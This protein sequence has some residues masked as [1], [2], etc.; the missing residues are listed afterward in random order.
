MQ[1]RCVKGSLR[2]NLSWWQANISNEYIIDVI[3]HGYR[4]PLLQVPKEEFLKNNQSARKEPGFVTAE[5]QK[6]LD[7]GI[8]KHLSKPPRVVNAL[9]VAKNASNKLRLVLDLRTVNPLLDVPKYKFED[10]SIASEYFKQGQYMCVFDLKSG[11]HHVDIYESDQDYFGFSWNDNFY[12]FTSLAFG[13]SSAGLIFSKI[14]REMV[15]RWRAMGI[16]IVTYLDDGIL[17]AN[18]YQE[19]LL[20]AKII[21]EDLLSAGFVL[22]QEKSIWEPTQKVKWLGFYLDS[23]NDVFEVPED[24]LNRIKISI[25]NLV[26]FKSTCSARSLAKVVGKITCLFH[27][28]GSIVYIMTKNCQIWIA[29][30]HSWGSKSTLPNVVLQEL[31]FWINN[32][33]S[34]ERMHFEKQKH[35]ADTIIYSDA[36]ATGARAFILNSPGYELVEYWREDEA[37][38]SSTWREIRTVSLFLD[39]H[40]HALKN[41]NITWY[42]DNQAVPRIVFKGSMKEDLQAESLLI[43]KECLKS[44]INLQIN[45]IPREL[46]EQADELSK[47]QDRDDWEVSQHIFDFLNRIHGKFTVD[48]FASN[49]SKKCSKFY[50]KY[51]CSNVAG[52]NALSYDWSQE[53]VWLVPP[54]K[55]VIQALDHC[56]VCNAKGILIVPKWYSAI[57][58]PVIK[59]LLNQGKYL[60]ILYEYKNPKG[61]FKSCLFGNDIFTE[62]RFQSNVLVIKINYSC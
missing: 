44:N 31:H 19:A 13:L 24:K 14:V 57:Y 37:C 28:L 29:D 45:W 3:K 56:K 11:Y 20:H 17:L 39:V 18:S 49:I 53:N 62:G 33:C 16:M 25:N 42:T 40:K 7:T 35:K 46:N 5:I 51:W 32:L 58:W 52:V 34:I 50:A 26:L 21:K 61:F 59:D 10:I 43:F 4:L 2:R 22:N 30:R 23:L 54:P 15:K 48:C 27:A 60:Q 12:S 36:S 55:L 1:S 9:T 47:I 38:R 8:V 41:R 6:L